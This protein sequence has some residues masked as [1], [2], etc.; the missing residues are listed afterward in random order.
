MLLLQKKLLKR[1]AFASNFSDSILDQGKDINLNKIR[2]SRTKSQE[3]SNG[4]KEIC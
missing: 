2:E 3:N 4:D 1:E